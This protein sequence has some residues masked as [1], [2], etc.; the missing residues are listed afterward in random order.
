MLMHIQ[1]GIS[2]YYETCNTLMRSYDLAVAE[3][4]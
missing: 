3:N 1:Q 4:L 2:K